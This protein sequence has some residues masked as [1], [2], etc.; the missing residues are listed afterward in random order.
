MRDGGGA[1][2]GGDADEDERAEARGVLFRLQV[3]CSEGAL[4]GKDAE[5][6]SLF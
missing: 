6:Q 5:F 1:D 3:E 4:Q 2:G